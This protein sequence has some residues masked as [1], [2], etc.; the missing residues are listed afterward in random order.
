MEFNLEKCKSAGNK[1][2]GIRSDCFITME[3]TNS[4][5]LEIGVVSKVNSLY[6]DSIRELMLKI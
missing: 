3:L 1:G 2:K 4:N 5:G 6:G